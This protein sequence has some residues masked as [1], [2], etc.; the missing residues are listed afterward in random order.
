MDE[1]HDVKT[2]HTRQ[3]LEQLH[4]ISGFK[5]RHELIAPQK[6]TTKQQSA[7]EL[8]KIR[9]GSQKENTGDVFQSDNSL[10]ENHAFLMFAGLSTKHGFKG[11]DGAKCLKET[12]CLFISQEADTL[13]L[14]D[15][16]KTETKY[17]VQNIDG[18]KLFFGIEQS[19]ILAKLCLCSRRPF[20]VSVFN[21]DNEY[22]MRIQRGYTPCRQ[23]ITVY[24]PPEV[25]IGTI[26][27]K[28][29]CSGSSFVVKN[30]KGET[31]HMLKGAVCA[32]APCRQHN[33]TILS[34]DGRTKLGTISNDFEAHDG[35]LYTN[36]QYLG[37][38]FPIDLDLK[39]KALLMGATFLLT[40]IIYE[41]A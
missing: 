41:N 20:K 8:T 24:I 11:L 7:N 31:V 28:V 36:S 25:S 9:S 16:N 26:K 19:T 17:V 13:E 15:G 18:D 38:Q 21:S 33:F 34:R 10:S 27:E 4:R 1:D 39:A 32:F 37:V 6:C 35:G 30:E 14:A 12:N 29:T 22:V 40:I 5:T 23:K 3:L 2:R